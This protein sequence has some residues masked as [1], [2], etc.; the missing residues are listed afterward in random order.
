M[1]E[2]LE[3]IKGSIAE[4]KANCARL[5]TP[6]EA[7]RKSYADAVEK[8]EI[9]GTEP[10]HLQKLDD[11]L[12]PY[13]EAKDRL[14]QH[15]DQYAKVAGYALVDGVVPPV[16]DEQKRD[17]EAARERKVSTSVGQRLIESAGYKA[18]AALSEGAQLGVQPIG[19]I[20]ERSEL[21]TLITGGATSGGAFVVPDRVDPV[22]LPRRTLTLF[23]LITIGETD[24]DVV[25]WV[26]K[27]S[28]TNNAAETAEA[29][30]TG[31]G[32]GAAPESALAWAVK[33]TQVR[34]ITHFMP[35]TKRVLANAAQ[36]RSD[37]DTE[38]G[39][40]ARERLETQALNGNGTA[41]NL[42]GI[43]QTS[44][45]LT[46]ALGADNRSDAIHKGL[47]QVFKEFFIPDAVMLT[48]DDA[49]QMYLEKDA[50]GQYIYG[51]P[52]SPNR[53]TIWGLRSVVTPAMPASTGLVGAFRRGA[54]LWFR[55]GL[56]ITA[57]DSHDDFFTRRMVA[58][59]AV[60]QG[61]FAARYP[62]AF[63]EL[64]GF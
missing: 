52:S 55:E 47:T 53:G 24:Q 50:N 4:E 5:W 64:T 39:D 16:S 49:E 51:P 28:R 12:K 59:M 7:A 56:V 13:N 20:L 32:S 43:L 25:E 48:P 27:T 57:S 15:E 11:A 23:D 2:L 54:T 21:K 22:D 3:K 42:R 36:L 33:T 38:L 35:V 62:K 58:I 30:A 46:Q 31:D 14:K 45:R 40:G 61:A 9:K 29:G 10:E 37:I 17:I 44:G 1:K 41:P 19:K 63:C 6:F 26:E 8:G 34:D 18:L 60:I